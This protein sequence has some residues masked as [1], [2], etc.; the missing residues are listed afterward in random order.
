MLYELKFFLD[1]VFRDNLFC[2]HNVYQFWYCLLDF[3]FIT[4]FYFADLLVK[5]C[6]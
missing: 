6:G 3:I 4:V 2:L 1:I 5:I